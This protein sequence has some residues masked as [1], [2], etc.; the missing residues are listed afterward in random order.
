MKGKGKSTGDKGSKGGGS[1]AESSGA[2][3]DPKDSMMQF[4]DVKPVDHTRLCPRYTAGMS[5]RLP[6]SNIR[7]SPMII[8]Y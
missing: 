8:E 3:S 6:F 7:D 5:H 4:P 2:G 1:N